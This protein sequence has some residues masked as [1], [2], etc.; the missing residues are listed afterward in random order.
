MTDAEKLKAAIDTV[1]R[2][3]IYKT[4]SDGDWEDFPEIGEYDWDAVSRRA[5][6]L[7]DSIRHSTEAFNAAY[8]LLEA[9]ADGGES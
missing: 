1:A 8:A 4:A 2:Q 5:Q 6:E 7:L 3:L 9:R